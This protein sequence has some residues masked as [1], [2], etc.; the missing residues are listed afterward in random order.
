[1]ISYENGK[2]NSSIVREILKDDNK[3]DEVVEYMEYELSMMKPS[4]YP[5]FT[6]NDDNSKFDTI[7]SMMFHK[8]LH[9]NCIKVLTINVIDSEDFKDFLNGIISYN[10]M[11]ENYESCSYYQKL[12]NEIENES[13]I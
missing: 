6:I 12:L 11:E 13:T 4:S 2:I 8:E 9:S 5:G 3:I 10:I 1:M 7:E